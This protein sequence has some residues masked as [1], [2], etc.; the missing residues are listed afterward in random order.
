MK[1]RLCITLALLLILLCCACGKDTPQEPTVIDGKE[2]IV[3]K[4]A[5]TILHGEDLYRA[6]VSSSGYSIEYPDGSS[7]N[8]SRSGNG[9]GFGTW[10]GSLYGD[11]AW[12]EDRGYL[13]EDVVLML[14]GADTDGKDGGIPF[15]FSLL[16]IGIGLWGL[17]APHSAWYLS[18]GWRYKN[19][20]PS[21]LAL[22]LER[23][24]GG[25]AIIIGILTI[26][27]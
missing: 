16:L 24:G 5:G 13:S 8:Y 12:P 2:V 17:L 19:A 21:D 7:Y 18:H 15:V 26:F 20:E 9:T 3:D 14:L 11:T 27:W 23:I 4:A 25:I 1:R 10:S 22:A 6:K